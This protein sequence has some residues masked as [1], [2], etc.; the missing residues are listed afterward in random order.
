MTITR[1]DY[2]TTVD[3]TAAITPFKTQSQGLRNT[4]VVNNIWREY[5]FALMVFARNARKLIAREIKVYYS[6]QF[7]ILCI[8][9]GISVVVLSH[10]L[11]RLY[12]I[13]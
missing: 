6:S 5:D 8:Y 2:I 1:L 3:C 10:R 7:T 9:T 13:V 11:S 4:N 12:D